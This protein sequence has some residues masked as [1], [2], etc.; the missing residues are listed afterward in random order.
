MAL[1]ASYYGTD[2]YSFG[3]SNTL[4]GMTFVMPS[5][6]D[7][8]SHVVIPL[9][10][11]G[12][13]AGTC[14]AGIY[15]TS[16]GLPTG[17]FLASATYTINSI[18][19]SGAN[20]ITFDF[21]DVA[22]TPG[23][24]Y[25]IVFKSNGTSSSNTVAWR[26]GGTAGYADGQGF[27]NSSGSW[28][29]WD[30]DFGFEV[31]GYQSATIPSVTTGTAGT[32]TLTSIPVNNNNVTSDGGATIT[33]RGLCYSSTN[34]NPSVSDSKVTTSGTT[35][36]FNLTISSLI[37]G[38]TYYIRAFA[39][40]SQG[41]AY[42]SVITVSTD[43]DIPSVTTGSASSITSTSATLAGNVT[44]SN[45]STVTERGVV[46]STSANPT[47]ADNKLASG[48]GTGSFTANATSLTPSQTYHF[49]AYA[50]NSDGTAYGSDATFTTKDI[51][52]K[53]GQKFVATQTGILTGVGLYLKLVLGSTGV[54][55]V[56]IYSDNAGTP[57]TLLYTCT[58]KNITN[59][60]YSL[61]NFT[62]NLS[63]TSGTAYWIILEDL[64]SVGNYH[65]KWGANTAGGYASGALKYVLSSASTT[66]VSVTTTQ[67]A[68]TAS[69]QP[70]LTV[71]Y[72]LQ[73][74][75]KKR[76]I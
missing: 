72:D 3:Y 29:D 25:A 6:Y 8:I 39:T 59:T 32:P 55:K 26:R 45:G 33:Q 16:G 30:K 38:T 53:W 18:P 64:Y 67:S 68:F 56:R 44:N 20:W 41:T 66:W 61:V 13:V 27:Y 40:N 5:G 49:R 65:I 14:E 12:S 60:S 42:G 71:D 7:R 73:V 47:T 1:L 22:V 11:I 15:N 28:I 63:I 19:T 70:T 24:R 69:E 76:Y 74:T 21:S 57:N 10:R 36:S 23:A 58:S 31:Y 2:S 75:Y 54:A 9:M 37:A 4:L 43:T 34:T 46:Y 17:G 35:G 62:T 51:V 50:I 48:S 52:I